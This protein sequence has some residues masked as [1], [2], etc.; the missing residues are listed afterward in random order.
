MK[1]IQLMAG[2]A[3]LLILN[4]CND[5]QSAN[6]QQPD[7]PPPAQVT[8]MQVSARD[9]PVRFE[10][11][12]QVAGSHE[13]EVRTRVTGIIEKRLYHEGSKVSAGDVLFRLDDAPYKAQLAQAEA[14]LAS[15]RANH[16]AAAAQLKKA[17]R[18][19][20]RVAP[21]SQ[22]KLLSQSQSDDA[23]SGVDLAKAAV[24]Q[25]EAAILQAQA[26][27]D[28]ARINL[29]YTE[30]TSPISGIAGRAMQMEGSLA[31]A[32]ADSLLTTVSQI[33]PVYV[34][35]GVAES[36][37]L[38]RQQDIANGLLTIPGE[39]FDI[40]LQTTAGQTLPQTGKLNFSDY[41]VDPATGNFSMRASVANPGQL[42]A[43]G[44]FVRVLL[45]GGKRPGAILA[46][47]R[48]VMDNPQGK[49]V[50][51]VGKGE[52]GLSIA[53]LRPV[54]VG[55]WVRLEEA[56]SDLKHAWIIK[57]GLK[58][59]DEVIVEGMA[60]IFFPGMPVQPSTAEKPAVAR[61]VSKPNTAKRQPH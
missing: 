42:L 7:A 38:Q 9:A 56:E 61:N 11:V 3:V 4:G 24:Q 46:P 31:Q 19:L 18:D 23:Q 58:E 43:P 44:Q 28:A 1:T 6:A 36:E 55:E 49:Y 37:H 12:G 53:E 32:G 52:N 27:I 48:A 40:A 21:L 60:R 25:A 20:A 39:G 57:S 35:F 59:N 45:Q 17:R 30:L 47:Q 13:I 14:A 10:Y 33:D 22:R 50:Y 5:Q 34:N 15:A 51:V 2:L 29:D 54:V 41:K 26:N 16:A 8:T